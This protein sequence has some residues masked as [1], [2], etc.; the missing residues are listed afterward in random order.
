MTTLVKMIQDA[1]ETCDQEAL[2]RATNLMRFGLGMNYAQSF[3]F[4]H[5][6]TG[7]EQPAWDQ[8]LYDCDS[9]EPQ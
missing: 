4:A 2:R 7:I 1:V 9:E 5:K 6:H 3:A 8:L